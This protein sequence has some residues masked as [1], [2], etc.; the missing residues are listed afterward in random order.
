MHNPGSCVR[1]R[2]RCAGMLL[3]LHVARLA[4][5]R[6]YAIEGMTRL[7]SDH[8]LSE[9]AHCLQQ[10]CGRLHTSQDASIFDTDGSPRR[11]RRASRT[12][13][14]M[15]STSQALRPQRL[16]REFAAPM[17]SLSREAHTRSAA[18]LR[19]LFQIREAA[20]SRSLAPA[21]LWCGDRRFFVHR[22]NSKGGQA[23][24]RREHTCSGHQL[25]LIIHSRVLRNASV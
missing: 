18:R 19:R 11:L 12:A 21:T 3:A 17:L 14:A 15:T 8:P 9:A 6:P 5:R 1:W 2:S 10:A 24:A 25:S 13:R 16:V 4:F 22:S 23:S 7:P 20:Y